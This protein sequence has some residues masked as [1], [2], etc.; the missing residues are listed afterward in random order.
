MQKG[1]L[2]CSAALQSAPGGLPTYSTCGSW[3]SARA[4]IVWELVTMQNLRLHSRPAEQDTQGICGHIKVS[5]VLEWDRN[6]KKF[7]FIQFKNLT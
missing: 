7:P 2:G 1:S 3:A 6:T 5:E 4:S